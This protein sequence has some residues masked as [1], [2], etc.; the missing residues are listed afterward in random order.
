MKSFLLMFLLSFS[1]ISIAG[2]TCKGT[3]KNIYKWDHFDTLSIRL[4]L[5]NGNISNYIS[6]PTKSD[7]S[8]AL[9]AYASK[10]RV[11]IY[12]SDES[13]TQCT[14]GWDHNTRLKGYFGTDE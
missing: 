6:M 8:L 14:N 5:D 11:S 13:V 2:T 1:L 4:H 12:W 7:E 9:M 3:I 10:T